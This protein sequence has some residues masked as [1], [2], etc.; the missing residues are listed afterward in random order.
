MSS[1][2]YGSLAANN[3]LPVSRSAGAG[4]GSL[5]AT[6]SVGYDAVGNVVTASD[7][8][9]AVTGFSYD[10]DR[11][12]TL[13]VSPDPDGAGAL[14][15]R[16]VR[17]SYN[18]DGTVASVE[19]GTA[20]ADGTGFAS[21]Q[22]VATSYDG[23]LRKTRDVLSAGGTTYGVTQ[24]SYDAVG[25]AECTAQRMNSGAWGVLP[26]SACTAQTAGSYGPDRIVKTSYDAAG[27]VTKVQSAYGVSGTQADE[28]TAAYNANGTT[29]SVTDAEGN[30]TTYDY[31]GVDRLVKTTYPSTTKGAGT[32]NASDY[33]QLSYD[34]GGNV[35]SR[36]LRDGVS[37]GYSYDALNRLTQR[38]VPSNGNPDDTSV[39]YTYDL[40]GRPL[41]AAKNA[42]NQTA[43]T[44]DALGRRTGESNYYYAITNSY[45]L[46]GRRTR[47]AWHDGFYVDYA[48]DATG[49]MTAVGRH[50]DGSIGLSVTLIATD[51]LDD[52]EEHPSAE[53][54][55]IE[56]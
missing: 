22:Q 12:R 25:R 18:A 31:D 54:L 43:F 23:A 2:G 48:Y 28:A 27:Q 17:S 38:T 41:L 20:N 45:D 10:A 44:W 11:E 5:V 47:L 37:L 21:L 30:K 35:T 51:A 36:R 53:N 8:L 40:L 55:G 26:S 46:A 39:S 6:A 4:D 52:F 19:A 16:A 32:S 3:L 9:G 33:E 29:A 13:A 50:S 56:V 49:S 34:A 1:T 42:D 14:K 7:P 15:S 24:Y